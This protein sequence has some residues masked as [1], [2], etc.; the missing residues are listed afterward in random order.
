[1]V[2]DRAYYIWEEKGK[3]F[4]QDQE[5]WLLAEKDILAKVK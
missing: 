5:T 4:G 2:R 1:M 3:P